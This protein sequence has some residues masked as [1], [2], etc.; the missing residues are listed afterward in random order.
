[1]YCL[2][3]CCAFTSKNTYLS[4]FW[5]I[6]WIMCRSEGLIILPWSNTKMGLFDSIRIA[7]LVWPKPVQCLRVFAWRS[8]DPKFTIETMNTA[9]FPA[10]PL[11]LF[12]WVVLLAE[13]CLGTL[14]NRCTWRWW[15]H[16]SGLGWAHSPA[17]SSTGVEGD[18]CFGSVTCL[19]G[20]N[21]E[22][23]CSEDLLIVVRLPFRSPSSQ[24]NVCSFKRKE[25]FNLTRR[26]WTF[27]RKTHSLLRWELQNCY[28]G[29]CRIGGPTFTERI[30]TTLLCF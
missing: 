8:A 4:C 14:Q 1:M 28:E 24:N 12:L 15:M 30:A 7:V 5:S 18:Y 21:A 19:V 29:N 20:L 6:A 2:M 9:I 23:V 11:F 16:H 3:Y 27:S 10:S 25:R 13:W 22:C 26:L 17:L